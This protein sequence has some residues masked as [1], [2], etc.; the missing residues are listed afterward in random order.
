MDWA[1]ILNDCSLGENDQV[2]SQ[3]SDPAALQYLMQQCRILKDS[4]DL[5]H[6]NQFVGLVKF[7]FQI[8][9]FTSGIYEVEFK[10]H[11]LYGGI[12]YEHHDSL[13]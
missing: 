8:P 4:L 12:S 2:L 6:F 13:F 3:N 10:F 1:E 5:N 9:L 7:G 11:E